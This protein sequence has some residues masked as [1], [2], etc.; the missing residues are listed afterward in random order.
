M[1]WSQTEVV[2]PTAQLAVELPYQ[3][4]GIELHSTAGRS[5]VK[6]F[7]QFASLLSGRLRAKICPA[8]FARVVTTKRIS[9]EVERFLGKSAQ[10]RFPLVD[11]QFQPRHHVPHSGHRL[12]GV[13][14][15]ADHKV[16]GI[17]DD[18]SAKPLLVP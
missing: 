18:A 4:F 3:F 10:F 7:A 15:T 13:A 16:I 8:G 2:G 9:Q 11:R 17:V 12:F 5:L 1:H 6:R 14:A